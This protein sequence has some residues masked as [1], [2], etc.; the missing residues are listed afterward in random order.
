MSNGL[1]SVEP[2]GLLY[3]IGR[4]PDPWAWPPWSAA[5]RDGTFGNRYDDPDGSYRVLY[6][7]S[8][9]VGAFL[10]TLARF[11]PDLEVVAELERI[12][13]EDE[14][15]PAVPRTWLDG[16]LI[17]EATVEGRFVDVG[18]AASL[19]TLRTALAADAVHHGLDEIDGATIRLHVPRALTQQIS[20]YVYEQGSFAGI[21]YRSRL[22]DDVLNWA[23]FEPAPDGRSPR[24]S[25]A[26]A[27]VAPRRPR[28]VPRPLAR[29]SPLGRPKE[30]KAPATGL[31][32]RT[33]FV[34][35][36]AGR[37]SVGVAGERLRDREAH[38]DQGDREQDDPGE[39]DR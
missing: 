1:A 10:E 18:D 2:D 3:R 23:I 15:P 30:E 11:R 25:G 29:V 13:G 8:Q 19:A 5:L 9:R 36:P 35:A 14:L 26:G 28:R 17:G 7:S 32:L 34:G 21:R 22:G 31:S 33:R 27:A 12:E 39:R 37:A 16:R 4:H 20:R 24:G 6:A 38:P